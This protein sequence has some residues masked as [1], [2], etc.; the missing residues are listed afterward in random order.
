MSVCIVSQLTLVYKRS[1][2]E[3][4]ICRYNVNGVNIMDVRSRILSHMEQRQ[5]SV[6]RLAQESDM[7]SKTLYNMFK[8]QSDPEIATLEVICK[9]FGITLS[10]F[11][12][13][14]EIVEVTPTL[15][16][17]IDDWQELSPTQQAIIEAT[18]REFR[19]S[20]T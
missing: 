10:Q 20:N 1:I 15:K 11:F 7:S 13:D 14:Q 2:S 6:Y 8:R 12:A 16:A 18:M 5:W 9:A 4:P 3:F 19:K 17:A